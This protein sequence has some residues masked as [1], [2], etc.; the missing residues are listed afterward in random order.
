[1]V[2]FFVI[3]IFEF[4]K[5]FKHPDANSVVA[6]PPPSVFTA[7]AV[8]FGMLTIV[9]DT[10]SYNLAGMFAIALTVAILMKQWNTLSTGS[11]GVGNLGPVLPTGTKAV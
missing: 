11:A 2:S 8:V 4:V 5:W 1:M 9:G 6:L 10:V 3:V 7:A